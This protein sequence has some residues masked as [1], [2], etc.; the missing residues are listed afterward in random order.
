[1]HN[2]RYGAK[3]L[4]I[5]PS[6]IHNYLDI[7]PEAVKKL[8]ES[9]VYPKVKEAPEKRKRLD[10]EAMTETYREMLDSGEFK[11]KAALAKH[12][13]VSR[14]WITKVMRRL[15]PICS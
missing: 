13:G 8:T 7:S 11:N 10:L 9:F 6:R 1:M 2:S 12:F 5:D 14:A 4:V 15:E 3:V